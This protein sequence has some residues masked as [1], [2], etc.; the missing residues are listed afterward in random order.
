[1]FC[2]LRVCFR[3]DD[4]FVFTL[5]KEKIQIPFAG[6]GRFFSEAF[7]KSEMGTRAEAK[8]H[9]VPALAGPAKSGRLKALDYKPNGVNAAHPWRYFPSVS[10]PAGRA[11]PFLRA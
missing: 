4:A 10:P 8:E 3:F 1:M 2:V 5:G 7:E 11:G 6:P 9:V